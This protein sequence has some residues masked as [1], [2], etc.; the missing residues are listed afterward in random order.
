MDI[1]HLE[2][3]LQKMREGK[4]CLGM[5]VTL[6]D[7]TVCEAAGDAGLDFTWIDMEH[8]PITIETVLLHLMAQRGTGCAPLVRVVGNDPFILKP[9][10]ELAPAGVIIPLVSSVREAEAAV[11]AC[12]YPPRGIRGC[13][14]RRGAWRKTFLEYL[15]QSEREPLVIIQIEQK[16]ALKELDAIL[17]VDGIGSICVGPSDLSA[18]MHKLGRSDAE[19][20]DVI[21]EICAKAR[22]AGRL[23]GSVSGTSAESLTPWLRRGANWLCVTGDCGAVMGQAMQAQ[24]EAAETIKGFRRA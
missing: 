2:S 6:R 3:F 16:S 1:N 17:Q 23:I 13:G 11:R 15:E 9:V 7:P 19:V 14:V 18:S 21:D 20:Q 5:H 22:A 10:L 8:G 24:A 12:R 4:L